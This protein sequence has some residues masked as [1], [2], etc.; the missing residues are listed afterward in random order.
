[1]RRTFKDVLA[2]IRRS[3]KDVDKVLDAARLQRI[4]SGRMSDER[5]EK[6]IDLIGSALFGVGVLIFFALYILAL[7][8]FFC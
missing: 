3:E 7:S 8:G 6:I 4:E 5:F 2:G 1:M